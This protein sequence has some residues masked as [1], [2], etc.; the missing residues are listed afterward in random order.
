VP[1]RPFI[2]W[3]FKSQGVI[4]HIA[5]HALHKQYRTVYSYNKRTRFGVVAADGEDKEQVARANVNSGEEVGDLKGHPAGAEPS[6]KGDEPNDAAKEDAAK[7]DQ[8]HSHGE[9][10]TDGNQ[11]IDQHPDQHTDQSSNDRPDQSPHPHTNGQAK[12]AQHDGK[13]TNTDTGP[14]VAS[15]HA[16]AFALQFLQMCAFGAGGRMFTYVITLDGEWRWTETGAEFAVNLLS[17]HTM[18]ADVSRTIAWSGEFFVRR[19]VDKPGGGFPSAIKVED[20]SIVQEVEDEK[21]K[22]QEK[23]EKERQADGKDGK[24]KGGDG[25]DDKKGEDP[26]DKAEE[27][28]EQQQADAYDEEVIEDP[29]QYELVIDNDSGT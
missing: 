17:K 2:S 1:F 6:A 7:E 28:S 9:Q 21:R 22:E 24:K 18:H 15:A 29:A 20:G 12:N 11:N 13:A 5:S 16:R 25:G 4:G 19:V 23:K 27:A 3:M 8:Q 10:H 14:N 26:E